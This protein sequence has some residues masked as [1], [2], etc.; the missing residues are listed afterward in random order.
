MCV[1]ACVGQR[2]HWALGTFK[3]GGWGVLDRVSGGGWFAF[4]GFWWVVEV[5]WNELDD[6]KGCWFCRV[7]E[8]KFLDGVVWFVVRENCLVGVMLGMIS[9]VIRGTSL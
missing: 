1:C 4:E 3:I 8:W 7:L 6:C 9:V 5:V 2:E